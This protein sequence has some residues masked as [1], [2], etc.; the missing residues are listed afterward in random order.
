[1]QWTIICLLRTTTALKELSP[2]VRMMVLQVFSD[3]YNLQIKITTAF[4]AAQILA[5]GLMWKKDPI[6]VVE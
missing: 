5:I 6:V 3:G 1:V 2:E 4:A